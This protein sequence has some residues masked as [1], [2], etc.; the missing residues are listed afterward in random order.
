MK[1]FQLELSDKTQ[2]FLDEDSPMRFVA[3]TYRKGASLEVVFGGQN[4][5]RPTEMVDVDEFIGVKS[6]RAKGKRITTYEVDT[7]RFIEPEEPEEEEVE[8]MDIAEGD[9]DDQEVDVAEL[10]GED[11]EVQPGVDY[12][13]FSEGDDAGFSAEQLDL[14]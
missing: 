8:P 6:H 14:F 11:I 13:S 3:M 9:V 10:L 2:F 4:A 12:N 1:R 5:Q 7:L